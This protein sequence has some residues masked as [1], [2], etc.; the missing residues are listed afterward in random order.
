L[1]SSVLSTLATAAQFCGWMQ[2]SKCFES[3]N[4]IQQKALSLLY[5]QPDSG[6][7]F[8]SFST[9]VFMTVIFVTDFTKIQ[10]QIRPRSSGGGA[11][12]NV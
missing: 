10:V 5:I 4:I 12:K 7:L 1:S 2:Q 8:R 6:R 11:P 9:E 3:W